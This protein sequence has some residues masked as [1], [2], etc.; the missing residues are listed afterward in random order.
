MQLMVNQQA[1][2][3]T[4]MLKITPVGPLVREAI[5]TPAEALLRYTTRLLGLPEN[6]LAKKILPVSFRERDQ[7]AQPG[8]QTQ[9]NWRWA[10]S[11]NQS[12]WFL[13]QHLA[14]Q[15]ASILPADPSKGFESAIQMTSGQSSCLIK[16]LSGLEALAAVQALPP[17]LV[18]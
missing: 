9:G 15:L 18:I 17:G 1:R 4:G 5:L 13:G 2:A 12:P 7:H 14:R 8:E 3:I 16:V 6:H 10:E 11:S